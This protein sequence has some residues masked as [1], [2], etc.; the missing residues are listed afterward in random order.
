MKIHDSN[1]NGAAGS[2][3]PAGSQQAGQVNSASST[4]RGAA[5]RADQR[6]DR[7]QLSDLSSALRSLS[8][9]SPEREARVSHL[10]SLYRSGKYEVDAQAVSRSIV[11]EAGATA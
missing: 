7:V 4:G 10:A 9:G 11:A 1:L 5:A 3:G 6:G 2:Q 8:A